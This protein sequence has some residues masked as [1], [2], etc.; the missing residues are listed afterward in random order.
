M[1]CTAGLGLRAPQH[2][3]GEGRGGE[4]ARGSPS[5][6]TNTAGRAQRTEPCPRVLSSVPIPSFG[7]HPQDPKSTPG[8]V[9]GRGPMA[10]PPSL[11]C[12][13]LPQLCP[14][15]LAGHPAVTRPCPA[16]STPPGL[17]SA[18]SSSGCTSRCCTSLLAVRWLLAH[19]RPS[20]SY[21]ETCFPLES[22]PMARDQPLIKDRCGKALTSTAEGISCSS[23]RACGV[24]SW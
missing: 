16:T 5:M 13:L 18:P 9:T 1:H 17:C 21:E 15:V 10:K 4:E 24:P 22:L 6:P 2:L 19:P 14:S 20:T 12:V 7:V 3:P 11:L 23:Q 8:G